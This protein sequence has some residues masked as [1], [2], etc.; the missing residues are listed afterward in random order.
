M[1]THAHSRLMIGIVI[2]LSA[3]Q[4]FSQEKKLLRD[5]LPQNWTYISEFSQTLP[6]DD[7]WWTN[8]EDKCLDSLINMAIDNNY[9]LQIAQKRIALAKSAIRIAQSSYYP[10]LSMN[11]SWTKERSAG[12]TDDY[13]DLGLNFS[14]QI[15]LFGQ[16]TSQAKSKKALWQAS[17]SQYD[18]AMVTLCA[19]V[20]T[21][22]IN[23]RTWQTQYMVAMW[24]LQSQKE[25]LNMVE[26]RFRSG[27]ASMFDVSQSKTLFL[28]TQAS[29]AP[30][31]AN[32][33]AQ[34]N[35]I[36]I[37]L[38][39]YS[40]NL[41]KSIYKANRLPNVNA[42]IPV[43]VPM[44]LLRRRPDIKEAEYTLAS[45]AAAIGIAKKDFLPTLSL[46]GGIGFKS[47]KIGE[48]FKDDSFTYSISPTLSW[49]VF[50]GFS[51]KYQLIE[52]KE[53]YQIGIDNYN[54]TVM[55]AV[56]EVQNSMITYKYMLIE[57][58]EAEKV[59]EE[60]YKSLEYAIDLYKKGLTAYSDVLTAQ[61]SYLTYNNSLVT[62]QGKA[63]LS[64][65]SI[66]QALGGGWNNTDY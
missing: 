3:I 54:N 40:N 43:G 41:P 63:L 34:I 50:D 51:R 55:N 11:A 58:Q 33:E 9:D 26:N 12:S 57:A 4:V 66:Y 32:I 28:S 25:I 16:I 2:L 7:K 19:N 38:G 31:V 13:F 21:A 65:I 20:A 30:L 10:N 42:L 46:N 52:A 61:Q 22:Y 18:G 35:S 59:K 53:Q 39:V 23:L 5:S 48:L 56:K 14:W 44:D 24:H 49:T 62:S 37:L 64:I 1:I 36:A 8:F 6:S 47:G 17:K 60:S 27:L 15:D 29:I 45:Y